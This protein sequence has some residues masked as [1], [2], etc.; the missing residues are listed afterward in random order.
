MCGFENVNSNTFSPLSV[1]RDERKY[2]PVSENMFRNH[3][4]DVY[5]YMDII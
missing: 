3:E 4:K 1:A 2:M 5:N